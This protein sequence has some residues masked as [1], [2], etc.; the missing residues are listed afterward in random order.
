MFRT[1]KDDTLPT[2]AQLDQGKHSSIG[3]GADTVNHTEKQPNVAAKPPKPANNTD[4][5]LAPEE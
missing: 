3:T 1:P 2:Q 5:Q 4:D